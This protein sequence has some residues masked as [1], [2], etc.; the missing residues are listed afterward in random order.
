[1]MMIFMYMMFL[2]PLTW[3]LSFWMNMTVWFNFFITNFQVFY[4]NSFSLI[5]ME[6][7]LDVLSFILSLLSVWIC[8]LMVLASQ[9]IFIDNNWTKLFM[10]N[11]IFLMI[12]LLLCFSMNMFLFYIFFEVSLI[13]TFFLIMGW[14][15][16][17]ERLQAGSY[18]MFYTI[19]ASL[20]MMIALFFIY[21]NYFSM[22]LLFFNQSNSIFMFMLI[23]L[24]FFIKIPMYYV[25]LWLPKAHVEAPISGSM[26]LAG[27]MLKL[28]GYGIMRFMYM[29]MELSIKLNYYIISLSLLGSTFISILCLRQSDI[30]SLIAYSSVSHMAIVLSSMMTLSIWGFFGSMMMMVGH[31]LCSSGLFCLANINYERIKSRSLYLNKSMI[32]LIPNLS[33]MWFLIISSNMAF[34][35]SLNLFGEIF[36]INS[37]ISFSSLTILFLALTSFFGAAYSLYLYSFSQ[38]GMSN[39]MM[40]NFNNCYLREYLLIILH[41]IPL[42]LIIIIMDLFYL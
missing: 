5:Y 13:P 40:F 35:P 2:I 27:V 32:N 20:P 33:L 41:W 36:M 38:H 3:I 12:S 6:M 8:I 42:N 16:Q 29:F 30:K 18:L 24:V 23:N 19:L 7:G 11:I 21:N 31:G 34:P 22:N 17:P 37:I 4:N 25:H 14:G 28:G 26:I 39:N 10:L 15:Y 9:L 1:M